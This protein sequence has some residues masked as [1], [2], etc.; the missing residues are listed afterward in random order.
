MRSVPLLLCAFL[1]GISTAAAQSAPQSSSKEAAAVRITSDQVRVDGRLDEAAWTLATPVTD[2]VQKEPV[3]GAPPT[4]DMEVRF[5]YADDALYVGARMYTAGGPAA[6][7][8]PLGPRDVG[9][10][11]EYIL[12]SLDT[13][14]DRRTAYTFGVTAAGVRL[15]HFHRSDSEE[16]IDTGFNPVWVART[17]VDAEGW[18]AE[19]WIPFSQLRFT[20]LAEQLWGMNVVRWIP[21]KNEENYWVAVPRTVQGWSSHF[22]QLRGVEAVDLA[23]RIEVLPYLA[24]GSSMYGNRDRANPF[25]DGRNLEGSIGGDLKMGVGPNLTLDVT[26]NPDFGQVEA[27][28]AVVNLSDAETFF[29]ER[30][31]FFTEGSALMTGPTNNY[32]YSRRI[33][34]PPFRS[35]SGD[36]VESPSNTAILGAGKL[37]GRLPSG[38]SLGILA[39]VTGAEHARTFSLSE[40]EFNRVRVAPLTGWG[41]ARVQQDISSS[42]STAA[43]MLTAVRRDLEPGSELAGLLTRNAISAN[44]DALLRLGGGAYEVVA[45]VGGAHVQGDEAAILRVQRASPRYFQRPDVT[46]VQVDP[47]RTSMT[48]WKTTFEARKVSGTH[49]LWNVFFDA[50]SPALEF[51]DIGRITLADG[52]STREGITYRETQP[53]DLFRN[54]RLTL[55]QFTEW[56]FGGIRQFTRVTGRGAVTWNNFWTTNT[57]LELSARGQDWRLT[58]GGPTMGTPQG[59]TANLDVANSTSERTRWNAALRFGRNELGGRSAQISG[60]VSMVPSPRWQVSLRPSLESLVDPRQYV[61]SRPGGSD[62][63]YDGR[64]IFAFIDRTTLSMEARVDFTLKPDVTLNVY[65]QPFA[66]SGTYYDFGELAAARSMHLRT[67]GTD[68]TTIVDQGD[69]TSVVTDG[70]ARFQIPNP[71]VSVRS[72]RSTSVLRWEWRPGSTFYLV[73]QQDRSGGLFDQEDGAGLRDLFGSVTATGSNYF[74][75]K[76]SYWLGR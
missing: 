57:S 20:N 62:A 19:M 8:A 74:A 10:Q 55:D 36:F 23:R 25:D 65:M 15:D 73:W 50:E 9:E 24:G 56:N 37:S 76:A 6:I 40:N 66:A 29:N 63:T 51:N 67:Y 32:F 48:G 43:A 69:G 22:G 35:A 47:T 60:G 16:D 75:V 54:Y 18:T 12:I 61:T 27:D 30:R 1:I 44:T 4:E 58:R 21:N 59:W 26:V 3:E 64:Y 2:F 72:F 41:V 45:S 68:G 31:P 53:G 5:L 49:W 71:H 7:Q 39:A 13:F 33:G 14:L 28:P 42:G 70:A 38:T 46:Y 34:A 11:A 52:I 17:A